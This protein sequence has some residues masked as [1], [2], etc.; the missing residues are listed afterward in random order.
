MPAHIQ[1]RPHLPVRAPHGKDRHAREIVGQERTRFRQSRRRADDHRMT[2]EQMGQLRRVTLRRGIGI[3]RALA[4]A[5]RHL[6]AAGR[7]VSQDTLDQSDFDVMLHWN[8]IS[9]SSIPPFW[10]HSAA[11]RATVPTDIITT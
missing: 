1:E 3:D 8:A 6:A 5:V 10:Y 4:L 2:A 11:W 9:Q 7:E